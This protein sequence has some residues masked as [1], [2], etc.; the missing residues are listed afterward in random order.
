MSTK[1]SESAKSDLFEIWDYIAND[2]IAQAD[3][4]SDEFE[5]IFSVLAENPEMGRRREE[6]K[7]NLKSFPHG[8][9]VIFYRGDADEIEIVRVLHGARDIP[10]IF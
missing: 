1:I 4:M 6:L 9:Y 3:K 5:R 8:N 2:S 10:D 7:E